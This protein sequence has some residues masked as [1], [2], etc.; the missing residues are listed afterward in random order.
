MG[1][2]SPG[3]VQGTTCLATTRVV[4]SWPM[5]WAQRVRTELAAA[6]PGPGLQLSLGITQIFIVR[7]LTKLLLGHC[8]CRKSLGLGQEGKSDLALAS[9]SFW[10][11]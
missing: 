4:M 8:N 11:P 3:V 1:M 9:F 5:R 2:W 10:F 6:T 7:L